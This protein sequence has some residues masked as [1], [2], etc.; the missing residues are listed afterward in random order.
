MFAVK[1]TLGGGHRCF[2]FDLVVT[3]FQ[4]LFGIRMHH[5]VVDIKK[6]KQAHAAS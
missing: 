3:T 6:K 4:H 1:E 5:G 2:F